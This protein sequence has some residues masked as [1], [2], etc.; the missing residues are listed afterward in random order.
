MKSFPSLSSSSGHAAAC[1]PFSAEDRRCPEGGSKP[2]NIRWLLSF[3][4]NNIFASFFLFS[5]VLFLMRLCCS[6]GVVYYVLFHFCLLW[7]L[8]IFFCG[9]GFVVVVVCFFGVSFCLL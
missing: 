1:L 6:L 3:L 2:R 5:L 7:R 4:L 9:F 8:L